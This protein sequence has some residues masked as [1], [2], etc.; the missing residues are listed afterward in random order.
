M[1]KKLILQNMSIAFLAQGVSMVLSVIQTLLVPKLLGV[2][3]YG[4]WQ[5]Y[6][7]YVSYVGFFH[8]GLS[9]GVY[10]TTGGQTREQMNKSAIKSQMIFG[11]MY[12]TVMA[13][14]IVVFSTFLQTGSERAFVI[15]MTAIYLVL[16][17]LATFMM[18][19]LQCMN[20]T[21]KSSYSTIIERLAFL[22]PLLVFLA[23]RVDSFYPYV[24][25]YTASTIVQLAYCA[26]NLR[27]FASASWLGIR[28]AAQLGWS[29]IKIGFPM[30]LAN[31]MSML[32]LGIGRAF[33]D[34]E[35]GIET[36]GKLSLAL[37]LVSFFLA[38]VSQASMVLFPSLRQALGEEVRSFYIAARDAMGLLFPAVYAF[39]FP[40]AW[41]LSIWLPAYASTFVYLIFLLPIC[42]FDSKFNITGVTYYNVLRKER[43]MLAV[44]AV[45]AGASLLLTL[46]AI[47]A[48][49]SV[50][51]VIAT[52][53]AV[54]AVRSVFSELYMN[55]LLGVAA[56]GIGA[57]E[58]ALTVEFMVAAYLLP[59][60][61]AFC[62]YLVSY[63]TFLA[64]FHRK[65][66]G[67]VRKLRA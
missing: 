31:I 50:F 25:A 5:L 58:L 17:N 16:Q 53:T 67:T 48:V 19:E 27:D 59:A 43:V 64:V 28:K 26:W 22:V 65:L 7:F 46:V 39:Y 23:L 18:N 49:R 21:K 63:V 6:I 10:L 32:I 37:S 40:L 33:I 3:Q 2:E 14:V 56:S 38:F 29:S 52:M 57:V 8:L 20:E 44:N 42:V 66:A 45:A 62:L 36:F 1:N 60:M 51:A 47:Y 15:V 24:F 35:W 4:Y 34:A 41:L 54:I 11:A 9:S 61:P 13:V 12:Q 55:R 30:M